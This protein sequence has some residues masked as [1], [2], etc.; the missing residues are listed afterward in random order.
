MFSTCIIRYRGPS[1]ALAAKGVFLAAGLAAD[2]RQLSVFL[3]AVG[4]WGPKPKR[5]QQYRGGFFG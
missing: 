3:A 2:Q 1:A 5:Y 4:V